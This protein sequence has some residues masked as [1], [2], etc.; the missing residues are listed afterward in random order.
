M[1]ADC[2]SA[3]SE[4]EEAWRAVPAGAAVIERCASDRSTE[5]ATSTV[6][7]VRTGA[8]PGAAVATGATVVAAPMSTA[9]ADT[10]R[11]N[12]TAGDG[13]EVMIRVYSA[14]PRVVLPRPDDDVAETE[15]PLA[16]TGD[17]PD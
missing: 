8:A 11:V 14:T 7:P 16:D 13:A 3:N 17:G 5:P 6:P 4:R 10:G 12:E 1:I 15:L 9:E 2:R